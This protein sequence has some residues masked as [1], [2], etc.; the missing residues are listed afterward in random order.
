MST[1]FLIAILLLIACSG[2]GRRT[3]PRR[4]R[5]GPFRPGHPFGGHHHHYGPGPFPFGPFGGHR[6]GGGGRPGGFG[7]FGG[8]PRAGGGGSSRGGGAGRGR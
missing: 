3:V 2:L 7:G 1:G 4:R 6:G 8:G 5:R